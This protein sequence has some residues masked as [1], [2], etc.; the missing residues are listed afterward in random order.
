M[1]N[2]ALYKE[3]IKS[4]FLAFKRLSLYAIEHPLSKD[5]LNNLFK[6]FD[7]F[8]L[9]QKEILIVAGAGANEIIINETA[10]GVDTLGASE[11]YE[12][13][14]LLKLDGVS[15]VPGLTF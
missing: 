8:L 9:D 14:K 1:E 2:K 5:I 6:M 3:L 7:A 15:F 12:K 4:F 11:L 10:V 13:F